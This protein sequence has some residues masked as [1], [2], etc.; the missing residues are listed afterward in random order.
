MQRSLEIVKHLMLRQNSLQ[1][2]YQILVHITFALQLI[3][4]N[5]LLWYFCNIKLV[6]L[7][8]ILL[9]RICKLQQNF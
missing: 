2:I 5:L 1:L 8:K 3:Y 6:F 7:E 4:C 9:I